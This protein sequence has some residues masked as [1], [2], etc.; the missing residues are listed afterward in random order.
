MGVLVPYLLTGW[1]GTDPPL[2]LQVAGAALLAA[3]AG[4]LAHTVIRFAVEGLGTPFPGAPTENLV[5]GGLYR[6]VRNPMYLAVLAII[7]GQA[8]ILGRVSW[9]PT[10]RSSG[11]SSRASS[12][13]TRSR[14]CPSATASSTTPTAARSGAGGRGRHPGAPD[15]RSKASSRPRPA[16]PPRRRLLRLLPGRT[17]PPPPDDPAD[18]HRHGK[19]RERDPAPG[20]LL[21]FVRRSCRRGDGRGTQPFRLGRG[22]ARRLLCTVSVSVSSPSPSSIAVTVLMVGVAGSVSTAVVVGSGSVGG[23]ASVSVSAGA[24]VSGRVTVGVG[25]VTVAGRH[26]GRERAGASLS[27]PHAESPAR[28]SAVAIGRGIARPTVAGRI[29]ARHHPAGDDLSRPSEPWRAP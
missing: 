25:R 2:A 15:L 6:Y 16:A 11:P 27:P 28:R 29:R 7:L 19:A 20:S 3:G 13:S 9:W 26:V 5:V 18:H 23:A 1:D 12:A 14:P 8:A 4:V 21:L 24:V 10:P 22:R 17:S